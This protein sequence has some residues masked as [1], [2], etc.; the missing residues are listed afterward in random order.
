MTV[1][2]II[3]H[4]ITDWNLAKRAQGSSDIPLNDTGIHD[5]EK[6]ADRLKDEEWDIVYSSD[7]KRAHKTAEIIATK[8]EIPVI[9]DERIREAY[10]GQ[11]EGTTKAERVER[12]GEKWFEE[13]LGIESN[14]SV[15]SRGFDFL[16]DMV[17]QHPKDKI[18]VVSHGSFI[19]QLVDKIFGSEKKQRFDNTSLTILRHKGDDWD[20]ELINCTKHL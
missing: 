3:R 13:D 10:G 12:W 4:G 17:G 7:L 19:R 14:E 1:V 11:I 16:N 5:A 8:L 9:T 2:G 15:L 6:L 20:V 18:L